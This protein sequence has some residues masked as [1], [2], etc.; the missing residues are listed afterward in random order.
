[1]EKAISANQ[2]FLNLIIESTDSESNFEPEEV[3]LC[4]N[5]SKIRT[6]VKQFFR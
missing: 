2:K 6:T 3:T 4:H 1:M 5:L